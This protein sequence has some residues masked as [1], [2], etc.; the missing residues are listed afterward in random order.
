MRVWRERHLSQ[1]QRDAAEELRRERED[2]KL[3]NRAEAMQ[4]ESR[5]DT[6]TSPCPGPG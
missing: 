6:F 3:R 2:G 1:R 4:A 5:R